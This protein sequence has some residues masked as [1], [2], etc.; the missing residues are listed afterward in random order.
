MQEPQ[1]QG[2]SLRI[3]EQLPSFTP[4]ES[5]KVKSAPTGSQGG[6]TFLKNTSLKTQQ[7]I[8]ATTAGV[9]TSLAVIAVI[10]F[11]A[12]TVPQ[13]SGS[14]FSQL[15][16]LGLLALVIAIAVGVT[17]FALG[18]NTTNQINHSLDYLQAQ[19]DAVRVESWMSR[20]QFTHP[21]NWSLWQ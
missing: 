16:P 20:R 8:T 2:E 11:M 17:T 15:M 1:E 9:M 5:L 6:L 7:L 13:Q 4:I 14:A 3:S 21:R 10:Q 18:Q 12:K 19:F